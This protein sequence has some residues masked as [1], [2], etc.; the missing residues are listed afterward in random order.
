MLWPDSHT[1][2]N[3]SNR[4]SDDL[5]SLSTITPKDAPPKHK[6]F[7]QRL[8]GS[9][10]TEDIIGAQPLLKGYQ[11]LNKPEYINQTQDIEKA[12][13]KQLHQK[14]RKPNLSLEISDI[15][16]TKSRHLEFTTNRVVNPLNPVYKLPSYETRAVT[17]P[18]FIRDTLM[19]DDIEGSKPKK[20]DKW[21]TRDQISIKDIDGARAKLQHQMIKPD[22]M[23]P[24]DIIAK[25]FVSK[26]S[27]NPLEPEY[28]ARNEQG[29]IE[30]IGFI[31]GSKSKNIINTTNPGH[32]R[33]LDC[34]DIEGSKSNTVGQGQFQSK[35]RNYKKKLVDAS[36]IEGTAASSYKKGIKTNRVTNPLEPKYAWT[37]EDSNEKVV[38]FKENNKENSVPKDQE[39]NNKLF[40]GVTPSNSRCS[41]LPPSRPKSSRPSTCRN[42]HNTGF[43]R[44]AYKFYD[45]P[46]A[47]SEMQ[48]EFN[49]NTEKFFENPYAKL[50]DKFLSVANPHTIYRG[51]KE[52]KI[53][54]SA[55]FT[56]NLKK[57]CGVSSKSCSRPSSSNSSYRFSLSRSEIGNPT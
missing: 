22:F 54:D 43:Q 26:R 18:K 1:F 24:K 9:L 13:P 44:N 6:I 15:E 32:R 17:P 48:D 23:D 34:A 52:I 3:R 12:Y 50:N 40:W 57:F 42:T 29:N 46:L 36:D 30:T 35:N 20:V 14:L 53:V 5:M 33:N 11:Y 28:L 56:Q 19:N 7:K 49:K 27:T 4:Y 21:Q 25:G 2:P 10:Q 38:E 8:M 45:E 39:K 47:D 16:G 55:Q 31:E 37:T 51:K 41:S